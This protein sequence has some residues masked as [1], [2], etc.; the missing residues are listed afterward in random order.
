MRHGKPVRY[1]STAVPV[2]LDHPP[3]TEST[4]YVQYIAYYKNQGRE[5]VISGRSEIIHTDSPSQFCM[6]PYIMIIPE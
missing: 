1:N 5:K 4:V 3:K 2:P 6:C